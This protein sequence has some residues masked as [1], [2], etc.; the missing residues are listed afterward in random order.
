MSNQHQITGPNNTCRGFS[1]VELMVALVI[2]LILLAGVGQIFL[3]SK[4]SFNVQDSLGRMQENGRYA[5][6]TIIADLRRAGYWGGNSE[7]EEIG[8]Y[9]PAGVSN[10]NMIANENGTCTG[11]TW[12]RMLTHRI[13]GKNDDRTGYGCLPT[14]TA[15]RGDILVLRFATPWKI[16]SITTPAGFMASNPKHFFLRSS[17][18]RGAL[19]E[20]E[21][22][23]SYPVTGSAVRTSELLSRAYFIHESTAANKCTAAGNVPSLYRFSYINGNPVSEEIAYGVDQFQV[24]YGLDTDGDNSVDNYADAAGPADAMW[25]QAIA[26]RIWLLVR[27]ECPETGY[28]NTNSYEMGDLTG[29]AAYTPNDSYRRQLFSSTVRMRN[30]APE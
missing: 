21:D 26:A 13:F 11:T 20:G 28:T 9:T 17:L 25:D 6:E 7:I 19:F 23:G 4:K 27:S 30:V 12:I 16:P 5:M 2:T 3:G 22:E 15:P 14:M 1:L 29:A 10:G 8:D 24:Q 18:F